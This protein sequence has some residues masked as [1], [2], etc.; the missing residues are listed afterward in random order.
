MKATLDRIDELTQ[1]ALNL[2][3][4]HSLK[5]IKGVLEK[6]IIGDNTSIF[7]HLIDDKC[8]GLALVSLRYDYVEGCST[9]PV[10]Y[11]EGICV[12]KEYRKT[13][14]ASSLCKECEAWAQSKGC[15]EFASDCELTNEASYKFHLK[16]GFNETNRII[17]FSKKL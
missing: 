17:H 16:I 15:Q 1:V 6:Y 10:G 13:G 9:S 12:E 3:P 4:N 7:M 2:W 14:V 5:D 8:V 11:L